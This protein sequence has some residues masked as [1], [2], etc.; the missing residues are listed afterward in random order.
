MNEQLQNLLDEL[1]EIAGKA[2]RDH[3]AG[4]P[5]LDDPVIDRKGQYGSWAA[6]VGRVLLKGYEASAFEAMPELEAAIGPGAVD[7]DPHLMLKHVAGYLRRKR[8]DLPGPT[9]VSI[10][11]MADGLAALATTAAPKRRMI[12]HAHAVAMLH[13]GNYT[14]K[15]NSRYMARLR[16]WAGKSLR[17]QN[18][19]N[20]Y[21]YDEEDWGWIVTLIK[22]MR[23]KGQ[24]DDA[25]AIEA[26]EAQK[27]SKALRA[28]RQEEA[29]AAQKKA[30]WYA[31]HPHLKAH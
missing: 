24:R 11:A 27:A 31:K 18:T 22:H 9:H 21:E 3:T 7:D 25:A 20:V 13:L 10:R 29:N 5:D 28:I 6:Q 30:E 19:G 17:C 1:N 23:Q 4:V 12:S 2:E 15:Q 26:V 8:Y 16:K 14:D